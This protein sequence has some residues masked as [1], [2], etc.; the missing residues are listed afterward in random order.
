YYARWFNTVE[1]N[2]TYYRIPSPYMMAALVRKVPKGFVFT[3]KVPKE[4]THER[5]KFEEA[6]G[7]FLSALSPMVEAGCLASLLAQFPHSLP[8][9]DPLESLAHLRRLREAIPA[10]LP[11]HVEF[12]HAFWYKPAV[13]DFLADREGHDQAHGSPGVAPSRRPASWGGREKA[14]HLGCFGSGPS[15]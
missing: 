11:M 15:R 10:D 1:I 9:G 3:V 4:M 8:R 14:F 2:S 6:V 12:R 5:G 7:P 13:L